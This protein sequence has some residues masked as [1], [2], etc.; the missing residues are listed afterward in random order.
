M[1]RAFLVAI[2]LPLLVL[3]GAVAYLLRPLPLAALSLGHTRIKD[4]GVGWLC[5]ISSLT[6]LH[7]HGEDV[8]EAGFASLAGLPG[9]ASLALRNVSL[10]DQVLMVRR[11]GGG[12]SGAAALLLGSCRGAAGAPAAPPDMRAA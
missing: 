12:G 2:T 11:R 9:L 1:D 3:A 6:E 7:L 4:E 10:S 8:G 5:G